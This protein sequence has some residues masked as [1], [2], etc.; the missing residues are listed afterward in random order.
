MTA[1]LKYNEVKEYRDALY[2]EQEGTCTICGHHMEPTYA[3]LDHDHGTG[4]IRAV[5]HRDCNILLGKVENYTQYKGKAMRTESRLKDALAG[6]Y[7]FITTDWSLNPWHP[8]HMTATDKLR[9]K[10]T[11]LYK[12]SKKPETKQKYRDLIEG[13]K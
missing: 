12:K 1:K 8:K 4:H 2:K 13:L 6:L 11:R 10:Y 5:I 3:V 9:R 7:E